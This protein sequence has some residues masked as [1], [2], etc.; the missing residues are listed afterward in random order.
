[1]YTRS[2]FW[3]RQDLRVHDNRGLDFALKNSQSLLPVFILDEHI[4]DTF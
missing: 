1:M 3:F 2:I 4:I